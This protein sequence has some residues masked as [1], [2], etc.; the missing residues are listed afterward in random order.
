MEKQTVKQNKKS[1]IG[2]VL[3]FLALFSIPLFVGAVVVA[4]SFGILPM[5]VYCF[6]CFAAMIGVLVF[7]SFAS[8]FALGCEAAYRR[9][10]NPNV[11]RQIK[12][13]W[14]K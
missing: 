13:E 1:N 6:F 8:L 12:E 5:I 2:V 11:I 3:G 7:V 9:P 10:L 4:T 14:N